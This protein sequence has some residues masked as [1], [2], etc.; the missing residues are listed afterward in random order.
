MINIIRVDKTREYF[1]VSNKPFNDK[2]L[3][4]EARGMMGYLLSKPDTW[5]VRNSDLYAQAP[6]GQNKVKRILAELKLY[7]YLVR[8][9][10]KDEAGK[11]CWDTII[12]E[13]PSIAPKTIAPL[14]IDGKQCHIVSTELISTEK[15]PPTEKKLTEAQDAIRVLSA[16]TGLD[17]KIKR[18][19]GRLGKVG[20]E[21]REAGYT[22]ADVE[23]FYNPGCWW[24]QN[25]FRGKKNQKPTPN[26]ILETIGNAKTATVVPG[27]HHHMLVG[28]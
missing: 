10:T 28:V 22:M 4:W 17:W 24:F 6:A 5:T 25:D 11:W 15:T 3:S 26:Q 14:S 1:A 21:L 20:K 8:R 16:V 19:V 18:N 12:Y 2:R 7:G 9:K 13:T 23:E 27:H